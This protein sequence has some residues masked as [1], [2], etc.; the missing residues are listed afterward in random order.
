MGT[1]EV[2]E[3]MCVFLWNIINLLEVGE[4]L[5]NGCPGS[6]ELR[7]LS[8]TSFLGQRRKSPWDSG[9]RFGPHSG[10]VTVLAS[11]R[12]WSRSSQIYRGA[13]VRRVFYW[14]RAR[15]GVCTVT[16]SFFVCAVPAIRGVLIH[17]VKT[18]IILLGMKS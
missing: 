11:R 18:C 5:Y 15:V 2:M 10:I 6:I 13:L 3:S 7:I 8:P 1:Y 17:A 12:S 9:R 14:A 16:S 4:C